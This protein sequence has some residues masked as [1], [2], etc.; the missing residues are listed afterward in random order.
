MEKKDSQAQ[1][2]GLMRTELL[3]R[4]TLLSTCVPCQRTVEFFFCQ[5]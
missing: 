2:Q 3:H 4:R 5:A 1:A